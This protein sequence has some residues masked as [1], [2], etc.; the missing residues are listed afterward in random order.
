M[1]GKEEGNLSGE[2]F[3][4]ERGNVYRT[5]IEGTNNSYIKIRKRAEVFA[6]GVKEAIS[7][8]ICVVG[9]RPNVNSRRAVEI[10]KLLCEEFGCIGE[11]EE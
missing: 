6:S 10:H 7:W 2:L 8:D 9:K 5:I 1:K 4:N 11:E 3:T